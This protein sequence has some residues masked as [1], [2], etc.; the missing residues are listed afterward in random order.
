MR[1]D[2]RGEGEEEGEG[3]RGREGGREQK[4]EERKRERGGVIGKRKKKTSS[5]GRC[6]VEGI[7]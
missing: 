6:G 1:E 5:A 4:H 3:G 7:I 2:E